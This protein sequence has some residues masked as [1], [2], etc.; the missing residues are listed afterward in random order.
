MAYG[1]ILAD[2]ECGGVIKNENYMVVEWLGCLG[3]FFSF[4]KRGMAIN[5]HIASNKDGLRKLSIAINE[6]CEW[7]FDTYEWCR[8]ILAIVKKNSI[9]KLI[10]RCEFK[11]ILNLGENMLLM[12]SRDHGVSSK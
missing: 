12:R 2:G 1:F 5:A 6:F 7:V 8:D 3:V 11:H 4:A 10:Q 9:C